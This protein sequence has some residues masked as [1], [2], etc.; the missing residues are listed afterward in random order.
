V[1]RRRSFDTNLVGANPDVRLD[2]PYGLAMHAGK[3]YV[4]DTNATVVVF[5]LAGKSFG[6]LE[7]ALDGPGKLAQPVNISIDADGTKY[8][9][10]PGR[11]QVVVYGPDDKYV[12]AYGT[13]GTWRPV[14]AAALGGRIYVA[15]NANGVVAVLDAA[16]GEVVQTIGDKG[17][18][19]ARLGGPTNLAFDRDGHLYVT[20][21]AGF[22]VAK[23][24]RD[25]NFELSIG[26]PGDNLG[27]FARPKGI[28]LD[29]ERRLFAVDASFSNVQIF[30]HEGRILM[31]FGQGGERPGDLLLPA[32]VTIDY[33]NLSYFTEYV[34]PDFEPEY[35]VLVSSQ[36]GPRLIN[37]FAFASR[38]Q[39]TRP[40]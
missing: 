5:D 10:D 11:G 19:E 25:G 40:T 27:H 17:E 37:V 2:K 35:L 12:R 34:D 1:H 38:G 13:E 18:P 22:R 30:N 14:D 4:C 16:S 31:F 3:I 29:R 32:K 28:A 33:D 20:D 21:F 23:F 8:V 6:I 39:P 9:A 26:R 36:F 7:G 24:D 15:D